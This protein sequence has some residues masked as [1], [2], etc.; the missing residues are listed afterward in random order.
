MSNL[1]YSQKLGLCPFVYAKLTVNLLCLKACR[2]LLKVF[3]LICYALQIS[4]LSL[5]T[6]MVHLLWGLFLLPVYAPILQSCYPKHFEH[7]CCT[8]ST[9]QIPSDPGLTSCSTHAR[10]MSCLL[11]PNVTVA[12]LDISIMYRASYIAKCYTF[13]GSTVK[14]KRLIWLDRLMFCL[15]QLCVC[16]INSEN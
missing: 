15:V 3:L 8:V 11:C 7:V 10:T 6:T 13:P 16:Q 4:Q 9:M 2:G 14:C 12:I 5:N 1:L